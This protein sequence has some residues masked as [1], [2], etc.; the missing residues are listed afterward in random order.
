MAAGTFL[1][2]YGREARQLCNEWIDHYVK[3][4]P[5]KEEYVIQLANALQ[6]GWDPAGLRKPD[7]VAELNK[8]SRPKLPFKEYQVGQRFYL[9]SVPAATATADSL[10]APH[11]KTLRRQ[12]QKRK[13]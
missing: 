6:I 11:Q 13:K 1:R 5:D 10:I 12:S 9:R 3:T 2:I 7:E 8:T 4:T